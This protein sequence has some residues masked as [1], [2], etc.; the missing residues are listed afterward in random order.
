MTDHRGRIQ[1]PPAPA[2]LIILEAENEALRRRV[3]ELE[4]LVAQLRDVRSAV[5]EAGQ[6]G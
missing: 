4:G 5:P 6:D 1:L 3:R 2:R